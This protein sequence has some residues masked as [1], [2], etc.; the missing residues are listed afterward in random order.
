[1]K[2]RIFFALQCQLT[3]IVVVA[4]GVLSAAAPAHA[5]VLRLF[6]AYRSSLPPNHPVTPVLAALASG[7][8]PRARRLI[9]DLVAKQP[10]LAPAHDLH[11]F[12]LA[13]DGDLDG[14]EAAFN[15][16]LALSERPRVTHGAL[17]EVLF[18]QGKFADARRMLEIHLSVNP[19][20]QDSHAVLGR[21]AEATGNP[22]LAIS[23]YERL[24]PPTDALGRGALISVAINHIR[25]GE[26][27]RASQRLKECTGECQKGPG[28]VLASAL[29]ARA[30]GNLP[31]A[32]RQLEALSKTDAS[33]PE[34]WW[35]LG[36]LQRERGD[37]KT[38]EASFRRLAGIAGWKPMADLNV[39]TLRMLENNRAAAT[40]LLEP[41][42]RQRVLPDA[43]A[44]LSQIQAASGD[45]TKPG[46]TLRALTKDF[47][48]WG[49]GH[50]LLGLWLVSL[51]QIA[52][53]KPSFEAAV[54]LQPE[55]VQGWI[56][57]ANIATASHQYAV[58]EKLLK[59]GL[60]SS[61][62]NADLHFQLGTTLEQTTQWAAASAA[63]AQSLKLRPNDTWA[64]VNR[65][66][67]LVRANQAG[68]EAEKL[69]RQA[70]AA[71]KDTLVGANLGWVL[72]SRGNTRE[73][74]PLIEA[75]VAKDP[76]N[77]ELHYYLA[78]A[79]HQQ[80][81]A[82]EA[83]EQLR[84]AREYGLPANYVQIKL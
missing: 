17:G 31:Q 29:L 30:E 81:R 69:V 21:I 5:D 19:N 46:Q 55:L 74:V 75:A 13:E 42:V 24:L 50:L 8:R 6:P 32:E 79:Y 16:A 45:K 18:L 41:L 25:V 82:K 84:L 40:A 65:A 43:Y 3:A 2:Q 10:R 36:A 37:L 52:P 61:P 80:G 35:E 53:A 34:V 12:L 66:R 77:A 9:L 68:E 62:N 1:M 63:Y 28:Y 64:M 78:T 59:S 73:G 67:T 56:H 39:A 83:A 54:K 76:K 60:V 33:I 57:L 22:R 7:D 14:A 71:N 26:S 70:Y 15:K 72:A 20:S 51:N 27:G 11:G 23:H 44:L 47:P 58:A 38:A 49:Q 48:Q 4:V